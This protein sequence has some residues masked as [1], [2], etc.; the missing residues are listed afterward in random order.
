MFLARSGITFILKK[1][2]LSTHS[3]ANHGGCSL[4]PTR[5]NHGLRLLAATTDFVYSRQPRTSFARGN[6]G[7]HLH[8]ATTDFIYKQQPRTSFTSGNHGLHLQVAT[9]DF[10]YPRQPQNSCTRGNH[11]L[12]LYKQSLRTLFRR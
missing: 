7:L 12:N 9:A 1:V 2:T 11:G 5:G 8:A 6:H 10:I 3:H 4:T